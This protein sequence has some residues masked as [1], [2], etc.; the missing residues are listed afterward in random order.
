MV[1]IAGRRCGRENLENALA[2]LRS[3]AQ[4]FI[5]DADAACFDSNPFKA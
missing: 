3:H 1:A 2:L 5:L 4:R